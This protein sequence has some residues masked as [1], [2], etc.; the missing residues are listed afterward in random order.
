MKKIMN[1]YENLFLSL[2]RFF[3]YEKQTK[4]KSVSHSHAFMHNNRSRLCSR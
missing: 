1:E 2:R 4:Q 3:S